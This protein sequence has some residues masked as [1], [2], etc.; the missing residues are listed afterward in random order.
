M[1]RLAARAG[2]DY[3]QWRVLTRTMLR[4]DLRS[5]GPL[6]GESAAPRGSS[7]G[8]LLAMLGIFYGMAGLFLAMLVVIP[9]VFVAGTVLITVLMFMIGSM[10]LIEYQSVVVSPDDYAILAFQPISSR[11]YFAVKLTNVLIYVGALATLTGGPSIVAHALRRGPTTGVAAAVAI[12]SAAAFVAL[13]MIAGYALVLRFV[14]PQ[15]LRRVLSYLQMLM[16]IVVYGGYAVFPRLVDR[17]ALLSLDLDKSAWMLLYPPSWYASILELGAGQLGPAEVLPAAAGIAAVVALLWISAGRLSLAYAERLALLSSESET[18]NAAAARAAAT[19]RRRPSWLMLMGRDEARAVSILVR[20]QFRFDMKFRMSVLGML[21]L[22]GLYVFMSLRE[23]ALPDPFVSA[24]FGGM[25]RLGMLHLAVILMPLMLLEN[26]AASDS[27]RA[28]WIFFCTPADRARLVL[29]AKNVVVALFVLP[30][31]VFVAGIFAWFFE[32]ILHAAVHVVV[33]GLIANLVLEAGLL[34]RPQLPF[35]KPPQKSQRGGAIF[36]VIFGGMIVVAG[37][38]PP[39]LSFLYA[40]PSRTLAALVALL[41]AATAL[42]RAAIRRA[43]GLTAR[44]EFTG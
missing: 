33:L 28:A 34:M 40:R 23:G 32:S 35:A 19:R 6:G 24:D 44:M 1:R 22:T 9:D 17:E 11:T 20:A 36:A 10:V 3:E 41:A 12:Y 18:S 30:Y 29:G 21:P 4:I 39:V 16:S 26:L 5:P 42:H 27:F 25:G 15:R 31:L 8:R 38:L 37:I 7:P 2:I 14:H 43:R 13:A